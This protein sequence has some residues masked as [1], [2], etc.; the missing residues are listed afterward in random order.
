MDIFLWLGLA[1]LIIF[2]FYTSTKFNFIIK[3]AYLYVAYMA[4]AGIIAIICLPRPRRPENGV[5]AAKIM[6]YFNYLV[7][8]EWVLDGV[9]RLE[10]DSGAVIVINHQSSIDLLAL[11][12]LWPVLKKAAPVAK[13]SLLYCGPFGLAAWLVGVIFID[14]GSK[15]GR[16]DVSNAGV[17]AKQSRTKLIVFPEG[18]RNSGKGLSMLP[19]KKGAFHVALDG[20]M[21]ILPIVISEYDFLDIRRMSFRPG[22]AV[23]KVLP[24]IETEEYNK[25]NIDDLIQLTRSRMLDTLQELAASNTPQEQQ[26]PSVNDKLTTTT[27]STTEEAKKE[28]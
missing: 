25:E 20:K 21:P 27:T 24:R 11:M 13:K 23:I 17:E 6:R 3:F 19:F 2:L 22:R 7:G 1:A 26:Q 18:T 28:L 15:T 16:A 14:R 10:V 4:M 8:I 12:E 5:L 9:E